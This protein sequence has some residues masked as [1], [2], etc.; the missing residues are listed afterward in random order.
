MIVGYL[1]YVI[2]KKKINEKDNLI[3]HFFSYVAYPN[4]Q[5]KSIYNHLNELESY[6][7]KNCHKKINEYE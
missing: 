6:T 7:K 5:F 1:L 3:C 2:L 4:H